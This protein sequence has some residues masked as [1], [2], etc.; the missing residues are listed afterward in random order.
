MT[1]ENNSPKRGCSG[2]W[3]FIREHLMKL[4]LAGTPYM[5]C[6]AS[7]DLTGE[8][9]ALTPEQQADYNKRATSK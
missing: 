4:E 6:N 7:S 5:G 9:D 3:F 1:S 2:Y 8:W